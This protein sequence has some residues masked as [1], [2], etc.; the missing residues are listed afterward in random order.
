MTIVMQ[1]SRRQAALALDAVRRGHRRATGRRRHHVQIRRGP[2]DRP[3]PRVLDLVLREVEGQGHVRI[4]LVR[5]ATARRDA[6]QWPT[7]DEVADMAVRRAICDRL[8]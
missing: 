3:D 4:D 6:G 7:A 5:A 1:A 8:R 2:G